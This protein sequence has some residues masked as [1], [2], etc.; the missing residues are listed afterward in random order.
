MTLKVRQRHLGE[1]LRLRA[2]AV[3]AMSAT[4]GASIQQIFPLLPR[5]RSIAG[6]TLVTLRSRRV[7]K[8][9]TIRSKAMCQSPRK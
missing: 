2:R 6:G 7:T 4:D 5:S 3:S 8:K 9:S 1:A